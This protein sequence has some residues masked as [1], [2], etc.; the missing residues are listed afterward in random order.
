MIKSNFKNLLI[1][2]NRINAID[3]AIKRDFNFVI[4]DDGFQDLKIKKILILYVLI[5][6]NL[7]VM[8]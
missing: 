8:V 5:K 4:L 6:N 7:S 2:K 1:N 3:E